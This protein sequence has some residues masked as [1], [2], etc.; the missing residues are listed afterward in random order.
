M[1]QGL[2]GEDDNA[3][4]FRRVYFT[5]DQSLS[6][7][8]SWRFRLESENTDRTAQGRLA[9]FVKHAYLQWDRAVGGGTLL[10]GLAATPHFETSERLW[11]YRSVEKALL[12][13]RGIAGTTDMGVALRGAAGSSRHVEYHVMFANGNGTKPENNVQKRAYATLRMLPGAGVFEVSGDFEERAGMADVF[14]TRALLGVEG[15]RSA[16]HAEFFHRAQDAPNTSAIGA[17]ASVRA[18]LGR[19]VGCFARA[20]YYNPRL[21][22]RG[23]AYHEGLLIGGIDWRP[24]S[25]DV[26]VIP[27]VV[28]ALYDA[29]S[30]VLERDADILLRVTLFANIK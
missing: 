8:T 15:E 10:A 30:E 19:R 18:L 25:A 5:Y 29:A 24:G 3:F 28:I 11:G 9:P 7:A 13:H 23:D 17:S 21:Q 14:L 27:N 12:D 20:D 22:D 1:V 4:Q 26:H 2:T 6:S 16:A